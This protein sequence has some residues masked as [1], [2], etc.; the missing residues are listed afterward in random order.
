MQQ[1]MLTVRPKSDFEV[2]S[3][4]GYQL[5]SALLA[6]MRSS[7]PGASKRIHD[8]EIGAIAVSGLS[9]TFGREA[10]RPGNKM[11]YSRQTYRFHIGITDPDEIEIFQ[12]L[13]QPLILESMDIDLEAGSLFIEEV[14]S[15]TRTFDELMRDV[16]RYD[17]GAIEFVFMSP[18][19]IQY[20]NSIVTEMFP[21]RVA[22]FNSL[23]SKWNHACP[24]E[25]KMSVSRDEFARNLLEK[26]DAKSYA[27]HSVMVNTVYDG[28][29]GHPRPI[30]KQ[31]FTGRCAYRF[32]R[33]APQDVRNAVVALAMFA[34]YSGVGSSVGRGCGWVRVL[35]G[36]K[37]E[38]KR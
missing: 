29:R 20:G 14:Q 15:S 35:V 12:S 37:E 13:I 27:T 36:A 24:G 30:F 9:G 21:H 23:L 33:D 25:L 17:G 38:V 2:P 28:K 7:N 19:C 3:S 32:V 34:E 26:P 4:T 11:L 5:Y 6:V 10:K 8:S 31:G 18:A 22:V 16:S 1:M